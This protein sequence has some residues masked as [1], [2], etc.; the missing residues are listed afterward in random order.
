MIDPTLPSVTEQGE[1]P[2]MA[3][4]AS[5]RSSRF[6]DEDNDVLFAILL[7]QLFAASLLLLL[8][9]L[10]RLV[11]SFWLVVVGAPT[12]VEE[13]VI[14]Y[15]AFAISMMDGFFFFPLTSDG[16]DTANIFLYY[17]RVLVVVPVLCQAK[18]KRQNA[19]NDSGETDKVK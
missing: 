3:L 14:E 2:S 17:C 5:R 10:L 4:A 18:M 8:L 12:P 6:E 19:N 1:I 13:G 11:L 15:A 7:Q 9:L 16:K